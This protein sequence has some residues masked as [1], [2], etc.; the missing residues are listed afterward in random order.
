LP[1]TDAAVDAATARTRSE[2]VVDEN[3]QPFIDGTYGLGSRQAFAAEGIAAEQPLAVRHAGS[4]W[5]IVNRSSFSLRDCRFAEGF[6]VTDV[7]AMSPG[8]SS[9]AHQTSEV[10]GPVF[11][12]VADDPVVE[13]TSQ[14][15]PVEMRG[16]T[17]IAVY[18]GRTDRRAPGIDD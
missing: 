11:T 10:L 4:G 13:V 12:C 3:G 14:G 6:S 5:T 2:Q 9:T 18:S 17:V 8:A 1:L 16:A 7:G 15:W